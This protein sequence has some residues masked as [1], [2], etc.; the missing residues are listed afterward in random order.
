MSDFIKHTDKNRHAVDIVRVSEELLSLNK[1][2]INMTS[3]DIVRFLQVLI[4][5]VRDPS[6]VVPKLIRLPDWTK[7]QEGDMVLINPKNENDL[8][9]ERF[10]IQEMIECKNGDLEVILDKELNKYFSVSMYQDGTSWV[11]DVYLIQ[12]DDE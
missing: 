9:F 11:K 8:Q 6:N 4:N 2:L 5:I 3:A 7:M 10:T 12:K 1:H